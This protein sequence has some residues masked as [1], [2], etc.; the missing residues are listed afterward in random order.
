MADKKNV[1][2]EDMMDDDIVVTFQ[3]E[4]GNERYFVEEMRIPMESG[5]YALLVGLNVEE[6]EDFDEEENVT[7]AK[8]VKDE[9]GE[10]EY[11]VDF[12]EEEFDA[13]VVEYNRIC[14]EAEADVEL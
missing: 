3:D 9:N 2:A 1:P 11:I 7:I 6:D 13:V 14:D 8:I 4:E 10:D 12:P 5:E